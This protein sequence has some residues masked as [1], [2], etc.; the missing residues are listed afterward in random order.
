ML[1][2][3]LAV[4]VVI[5]HLNE[6]DDLRQCLRS[7]EAQ[8][9][10]VPFEVIVVDNGSR[11]LPAAVCSEFPRVRLELERSPGP[12]PARNRG[13]GLARAP[14]ISF[15]DADCLAKK[16]WIPRINQFF[17]QHPQV[18]FIAGSILVAKARPGR[19]TSIEA[20]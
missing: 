12:G 10:N 19:V 20:Y 17:G 4:S 11:E 1:S 3:S 15:I 6:P 14:I 18:D 16:D 13:A 8:E 2:P 9:G 7:L 5:P